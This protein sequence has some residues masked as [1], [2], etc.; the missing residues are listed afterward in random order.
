MIDIKLKEPLKPILMIKSLYNSAIE[1]SEM[2]PEACAISSLDTNN[3]VDS[4]F[5]NIKYILD[6]E[7]IFFSNY[8]SPK[9][10]QFEFSNNISALFFWPTIYTQIR[11]RGL[12]KKIDP[13]FSDKHFAKRALEKNIIAKISNQSKEIDSYSILI[14]NF[15]KELQKNKYIERPDFWGGFSFKPYY[16]EFW[17]GHESRLNKREVYVKNKNDEWRSYLLQP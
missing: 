4:R 11:M 14:K 17:E 2:Y 9:A 13:D 15:E 6:N 12:I 3:N 7:L 16:F 5:V 10:K 8:N 1:N